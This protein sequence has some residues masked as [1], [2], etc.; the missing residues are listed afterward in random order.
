MKLKVEYYRVVYYLFNYWFYV[1]IGKVLNNK[2]VFG[3]FVVMVK[4]FDLVEYKYCWSKEFCSI[5][6][7]VFSFEL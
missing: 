1:E 6:K 5:L 3:F 2:N 4:G 7:Y